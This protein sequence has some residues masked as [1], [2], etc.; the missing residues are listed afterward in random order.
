MMQI[1]IFMGLDLD[2]LEQEVNEFLEEKDA[3]VI[4]TNFHHSKNGCYYI[5]LTYYE[6][7]GEQKVCL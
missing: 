7:K 1:R 3:E 6:E 5:L 4:N 2:T